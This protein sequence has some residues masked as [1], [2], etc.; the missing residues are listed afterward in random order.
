MNQLNNTS[1]SPKRPAA[2][3]RYLI[4]AVAA[5]AVA[6]IVGGSAFYL[7]N[8]NE[9]PV[10][11]PVASDA[12]PQ[13]N[14]ASPTSTASPTNTAQPTSGSRTIDVAGHTIVVEE[15][16]YDP[17]AVTEVTTFLGKF[18]T[19]TF[20]RPNNPGYHVRWQPTTQKVLSETPPGNATFLN[21]STKEAG[22]RP[23][24]LQSISP[25]GWQDLANGKPLQDE[26]TSYRNG[27]ESLPWRIF[28]YAK[29]QLRDGSSPS[30]VRANALQALGASDKIK[31][32]TTTLGG[33]EAIQFVIDRQQK[34]GQDQAE[35]PAE[36]YQ[37]TLFV[38]ATTGYLM[39]PEGQVLKT[40]V[41]KIDAIP[42]IVLKAHEEAEKSGKC[43]RTARRPVKGYSQ[44]CDLT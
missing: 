34:P 3:R 33:R 23:G 25:Q 7:N 28:D 10:N 40:I 18:A 41:K 6:T 43:D 20:H 13:T 4:P 17:A 24:P 39:G 42:E 44:F 30:A 5:A 27:K 32:T 2:M 29:L 38:D 26:D 11:L 14:T 9:V 21:I 19:T 31:V 15:I 8:H 12:E 22:L 16:T 1:V 36:T 35:S 37:R